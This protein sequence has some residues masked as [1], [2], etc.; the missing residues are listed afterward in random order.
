MSKDETKEIRRIKELYGNKMGN[1]C[2]NKLQ[3]VTEK[4]E[5]LLLKTL[6]EKFGPNKFLHDDLES[7]ELLDDFVEYIENLAGIE[8]PD[9]IETQK[10]VREL[11]DE[12]G[13]DFYECHTEEDIQSF[14]KYYDRRGEEYKEYHNGIPRYVGEELCTFS[15]GR[16]ASHHVFWV[17]KRGAENIK[18]KENPKRQDE[19]GTSV[20]SIQFTRE[21]HKLSIK[22]RYNHGLEKENPD[23]TFNS[24]VDRINPGLS[25]AFAREY[26]L[27][28]EKKKNA[29]ESGKPFLGYIKAKD[30][31]LYKVNSFL[32]SIYFCPDNVIIKEGEAIKLDK[33]RYIVMDGYIY[34]KVEAKMINYET[35]PELRDCF[36]DGFQDLDKRIKD[37]D[38]KEYKTTFN[39]QKNKETGVRTITITPPKK[40]P[41]IIEID[42]YGRIISYSNPNITKIGSN[43]MRFCETLKKIDLPNVTE[44]GDDFIG[45]GS[46]LESINMPKVK[47]IGNNFL[48]TLFGNDTLKELR[49]PELE[50]VGSSFLA[51]NTVIETIDLPNLKHVGTFFLGSSLRQ[52]KEENDNSP[53]YEEE[54]MVANNKKLKIVNTPKLE[55][56]EILQKIKEILI[57]NNPEIRK[58]I[59]SPTL[60]SEIGKEVESPVPAPEIKIQN[61][62]KKEK[63]S[64]IKNLRIYQ[65]IK[66]K[67]ALYKNR[68]KLKIKEGEEYV[69][70]VGNNRRR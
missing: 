62:E 26:G 7:Q 4:G 64:F 22:N 3:K 24:D 63:K 9:I 61:I 31:K 29:F 37:E 16:L 65:F 28:Y 25:G 49:L 48:S 18:R 69:E 56:I 44:I 40:E 38:G 53:T 42:K 20:M 50:S 6:S 54:K 15:G 33:S 66:K 52:K 12:I 19:Y 14:R 32:G 58:E 47:T 43:F 21:G 34:D 1:F 5:G 8:V 10:T 30:G 41:I 36:V 23:E 46:S 70:E 67:I 27:T 39:E 2:K 57:L 68:K 11:F 60:T 35:P 51:S 45:F 17:V 13:Y 55:D 59:E